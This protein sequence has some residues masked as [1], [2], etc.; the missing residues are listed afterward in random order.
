M[1]EQRERVRHQDRGA[2]SLDG[3]CRNQRN[4]V[5]CQRAGH[6]CGRKDRK[7]RREDSLGADAISKR[8]GRQNEGGKGDRIGVDDPLQLG[9]AAAER[10]ADAV[11][12]GVDNGDVELNDAVAKTHRRE[13]Q[14]FRQA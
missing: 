4:R 5:R 8:A 7:T 9:D 14:R 1:T 13:R 3:S 10:G 6:G 12:R 11:E 2:K